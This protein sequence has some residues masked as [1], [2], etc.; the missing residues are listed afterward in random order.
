MSG[1]SSRR[2]R[3]LLVGHMPPGGKGAGGQATQFLIV[4]AAVRERMLPYKIIS[5]FPAAHTGRPTFRRALEVLGISARF[6]AALRVRRTPVYLAIAKSQQGFL[7]DALLIWLATLTR[8]RIVC[9]LNEGS[10]DTFYH[11]QPRLLQAIIRATLRRAKAIVVV[12]A[13]LKSMFDFEPALRARI[14]VIPNPTPPSLTHREEA[15]TFD[16]T[17][18]RFRILYLSLLI[19][20]KGYLDVVRAVAIAVHEFGLDVEVDFAGPFATN[21]SDDKSVESVRQAESQ[22]QELVETSNLSDRVRYH[23]PVFGA[24]KEALLENAHVLVLPTAFD[25]EAQ[26]LCILEAMSFGCPVITTKYR[27]IPDMVDDGINGCFVPPYSPHAIADAVRFL[28]S[29]AARYCVMSREAIK[30]ARDVKFDPDAHAQSIL[31]LIAGVI[32]VSPVPTSQ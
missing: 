10:Y 6:A 9:H 13:N 20:S 16:A 32:D 2:E 7:R 19:E 4:L 28:M 24:A 22:F 11:S 31:A 23:G 26:P 30:R 1:L 29:D 12:S 15:K 27:G 18:Q 21:R 14:A 25:R 17:S 5:L 3:L 8:N